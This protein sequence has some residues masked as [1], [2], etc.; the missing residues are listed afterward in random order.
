MCRCCLL[1]LLLL[2][3]VVVADQPATN[4][5]DKSDPAEELMGVVAAYPKPLRNAIL[6]VVS[7]PQVLTKLESGDTKDLGAFLKG[8]PMEVQNAARML[9]NDPDVIKLLEADPDGAAAV[10]KAYRQDRAKVS[11]DL[12]KI[13]QLEGKATDEWTK[14]LGDDADAGN[15]LTQ[16][17]SAYQKKLGGS[18]SQADAANY[19]GVNL[20]PNNQIGVT[21]LPTPGFNEYVMNNADQ[22]PALA[23]TMVSQWLGSTNTPIY[24]HSFN[25]WWNHYYRHFDENRF[26]AGDA[27]RANRL[28]ELARY[29]R[30]YANDE[31]RWDH[32]NEHRNDFHHLNNFHHAARN[33]EHRD[34]HHKPNLGRRGEHHAEHGRHAGV[35]RAHRTAHQHAHH[36]AHAHAH[37]AAH[38]HG[39]GHRK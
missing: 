1:V 15:Q 16:A 6:T 17:V 28:G 12:D 2:T 9:A 4:K 26:L 34:W 25:N 36:A 11:A 14:R 5:T 23:N 39:G 35:H 21:A 38:H 27:N 13:E 20:E 24:D 37:H 22:Y 32:F 18:V 8:R 3:A 19:A 33:D 10:G 31:H 7:H 29:D 30:R